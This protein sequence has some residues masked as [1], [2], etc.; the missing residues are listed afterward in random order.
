MS[1]IT[2]NW[3]EE[4]I[5]SIIRKLDEKTGLAGATLAIKLKKNYKSRL[6]C[7]DPVK[8]EFGFNINFFNN[9]KTLESEAISV[10][11]HEYAHYYDR[12]SHIRKYIKSHFEEGGH[13]GAWR[14]A[15]QAV[16]VEA[17]K[18]H[19]SNL[20]EEKNW[21]KSEAEYYHNA[22]DVPFCNI[23]YYTEKW[24]QLPVIDKD[25]AERF[26]TNIKETN[27][28]S[29]Y[30]KGDRVLHPRRGFGSVVKAIPHSFTSQK[31]LIK[32]EDDTEDVFEAREICK[33]IN[34]VAVPF[35]KVAC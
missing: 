4:K 34:G 12:A 28:N 10:I 16:K 20:F 11:R 5:R 2:K 21:S 27:P 13:D 33:M 24:K 31:I 32:F 30:E 25:C 3:N 1:T 18:Y 23:L 9:P 6:G 15:C 17:E 26:L 7:Y 35:R 29:Y 22:E 14:W 8:N 19:R